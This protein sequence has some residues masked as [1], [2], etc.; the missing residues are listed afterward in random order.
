[1]TRHVILGGGPAANNA[2]DTIRA[3]DNGSSHV[4]LVSDEPAY[5]RMALPYWLAGQV[6]EQQVYT[7]DDAYYDRLKVERKI[8]RRATRTDPAAKTVTLDDGQAL[9]FAILL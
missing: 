1:M 2:I 4:T 3:L 8:G 6:P 7:A 9:P 5:A